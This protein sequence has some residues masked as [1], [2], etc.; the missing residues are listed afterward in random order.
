MVIQS[1]LTKRKLVELERNHT[2][3]WVPVHQGRADVSYE[4]KVIEEDGEFLI[5]DPKNGEL[6]IGPGVLYRTRG[7]RKN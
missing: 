5:R 1:V 3:I 7:Q 4:G 6:Y 2:V